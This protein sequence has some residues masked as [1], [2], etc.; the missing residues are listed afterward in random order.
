M[1]KEVLLLVCLLIKCS[2]KADK[3]IRT[4]QTEKKTN[5]FNNLPVVAII[6]EILLVV[7]VPVVVVVALC[8]SQLLI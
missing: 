4:S 6:F 1:P 7:V 5:K 2:S 8:G 3:K